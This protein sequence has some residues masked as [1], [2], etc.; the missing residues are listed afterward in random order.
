MTWEGCA[1]YNATDPSA[2]GFDDP[3]LRLTVRY[4]TGTYTLEVGDALS[5]QY[6]ARM[7]DSRI[8]YWMDATDV[9]ALLQADPADLYP[10]E[11]LLMDWDTVS[12]VTVQLAGETWRFTSATRDK[13]STEAGETVEAGEQETY[14]LL[15]GNE[16]SL[17]DVLT[18]VTAMTPTG[19][20]LGKTPTRAKDLELTVSR[21][22]KD[23]VILCFYRDTASQ[24]LVTLNG[25]S[26]VCVNRTDVV[27]LCEAITAIVLAE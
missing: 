7:N 26:T 14:W 9:N 3:T 18:T 12:S 8:I 16:V 1:D 25:E 11:V 4:G 27:T 24:S 15:N 5:G 10:N 22:G 23:D 17:G 21:E 20:A 19:S 13:V 6:Y 2:Y